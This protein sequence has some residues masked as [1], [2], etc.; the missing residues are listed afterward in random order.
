MIVRIQLALLLALLLPIATHAQAATES[1]DLVAQ[2][3]TVIDIRNVGT[4]MWTWYKEEVAPRRSPESHKKAE[5][6]SQT[7]EVD[8][9]RVPVISREDLAAILV[10]KY[11]AAIPTEDGW[12]HPYEFRLN[13]KDANA[14]VVMA[15][16]SASKDG[17][18]SGSHYSVSGFEPSEFDQDLTWM[19]G[20][21]VRWPEKKENGR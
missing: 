4:A 2:K 9:Q 13:T 5:Q 12:G 19:D 8:F 6:E 1:P 7:K 3:R 21:F 16:R 14:I 20:Y 10:P 15:V 17:Q 18:L 11:I